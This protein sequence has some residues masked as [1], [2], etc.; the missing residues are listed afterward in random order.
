[1]Y[2]A[3]DPEVIR[4]HY[5]SDA[6]LR[7]RQQIHDEYSI[8]KL[9]FPSWVL[10]RYP[11]SGG[12]RVLDAGSGWGVYYQRLK[13]NPQMPHIHYVGM[14]LSVGMLENHDAKGRVV[15]G[16]VQKLPFASGIFD[17]VMANHMLYHVQDISAALRE[18]KRVLKPGG[19][20]MASTNSANTMPELTFLYQRALLI[21][22]QSRGATEQAITPPHNSFTLENGTRFLARHFYAVTRYDLP[23]ALVFIDAEPFITYMNTIRQLRE[24]SLPPGV[25]W[26]DVMRVMR[27]QAS[28]V[29]EALG[30]LVIQKVSGVLVASDTGGG[31]AEFVSKLHAA[32]NGSFGGS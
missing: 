23:T 11:W 28:R 32:S 4:D 30:E 14:D 25:Y 5:A 8:P 17:V 21:L 22:S 10:A 31:T 20:L 7:I 1:M 6:M 15:A 2:P 13:A 19:V 9:D 24:P 3:H 27:Q 16:D 26:D 12:E 29:I 18:L